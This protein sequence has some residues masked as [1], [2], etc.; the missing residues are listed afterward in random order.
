MKLGVGGGIAIG[1]A[2][3][4]AMFFG[5]IEYNKRQAISTVTS[6]V[7]T[8]E[9]VV[10]VA[11]VALEHG[12]HAYEVGKEKSIEIYDKAKNVDWDAKVDRAR[13]L[14]NRFWKKDEKEE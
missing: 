11:P 4:G 13:E 1:I 7:K 5:Y 10:D 2:L 6:A 8:V 9:K 12:K 14:K 3:V